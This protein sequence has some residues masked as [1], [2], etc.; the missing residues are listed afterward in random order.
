MQKNKAWYSNTGA[1][2]LSDAVPGLTRELE[3]SVAKFYCGWH[4][5]CESLSEEAAQRIAEALGYGF[6][7]TKVMLEEVTP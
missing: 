6:L 3:P 1:L 4:F 7:G 2:M 5:V